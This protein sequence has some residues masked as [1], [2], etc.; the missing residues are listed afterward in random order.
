MDVLNSHYPHLFAPL[1]VGNAIL[2][3]RVIMGS[4]H[5]GLEEERG[6][7]QKL[8]KFYEERAKG[9]VGLIVTGGIAPN[10]RG[11]LAPFAKQMSSKRHAR[12]HHVVTE[13]VHQGDSKIA[14]QI[15][16]AGRY[17]YHPLVVAPSHIKSPISPFKPKA[18]SR[19][20]IHKTIQSF[21]HT[22]SLAKSC[23]YDGVEVMGSEGYLINQF[24]ALHT[25]KRSDEWGG[26]FENRIRFPIEIVRGIREALGSDFIII[27]RLSMIDLIEQGSSLEEVIFL[28]KEIERAGASLIN[29]G[30]GW[31]EARVPTIATLVPRAAFV[32]V[33][34]KVKQEVEL[35]LITSN[36][37]NTPH[38]A[39]KVLAEGYADLVS[40]ARPFLADS[41]FMNKAEKGLSQAINTCIACNQACLDYVFKNKK[42]SCLVNPRAANETTINHQKAQRPKSIAV[43]GAGPAG[44]S[45][46]VDAA[47]RGHRVTLFEKSGEIGG[48][49]NLAKRIPGKDEFYETIRYFNYQLKECQV[50]VCLN[51][52]ASVEE[53]AKFDDII[54]AT[55][56]TPRELKLAGSNHPKVTSYLEVLKD[57]VPLGEMIVVIGAG[58]I[59]FDVCEYLTH[60]QGDDFY[61][62]WGIDLSLECRGGIKPASISQ[63]PRRITMLQRKD[64]PLGKR[65]GKTTG[66]IHRQSLRKK[67][68]VMR[69]NVQYQKI[70]DAGL[71]VVIDAREELIECDQIIVCAGQEPLKELYQPLLDRGKEP[72]LIG[73]AYKAQ[74]LDARA[75]IWQANELAG[76]L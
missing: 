2:K 53:L 42:A 43:V 36:R 32:E 1:S 33:T 40:M 22:A 27:Y 54:L 71:H 73:G 17:G 75:A 15:L 67:G 74:E 76:K 72:Y 56:V 28:A 35:P 61:K 7:M 48:Q 10:V 20:G 25:N 62:E 70:D 26:S 63:S 3:N 14:L 69:S 51:H 47:K 31:H 68:V 34:K 37:I 5:T 19:R 50:K 16:H 52:K 46:S 13:A 64:E 41:E 24:I 8:A 6:G 49:F 59:G 45:F 29:T 58:G 18:L 30:I 44:L 9:G 65:L 39:E 55:G 60:Q 38:V 11:R 12:Q 23:G 66:W 57:E 4:M 21:I